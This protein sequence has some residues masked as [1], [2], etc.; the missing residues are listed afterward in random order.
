[1][2]AREIR[3]AYIDS[4]SIPVGRF[5]IA[6]ND[7]PGVLPQQLLMLEAAARAVE[8]A[9]LTPGGRHER[10]GA[11]IGIALDLNTTNFHL[12]W[13]LDSKLRALGLDPTSA[14]GTA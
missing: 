10:A 3:G 2:A 6:P 8:D 5:K 14:E 7:I 12:R 1:M 4:L 11:L 9:G 13:M